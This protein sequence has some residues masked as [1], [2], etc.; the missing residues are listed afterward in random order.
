MAKDK[1]ATGDLPEHGELTLFVG[2][3][4]LLTGEPSVL[5]RG[6][7]PL[8]VRLLRHYATLAREN[9]ASQEHVSEALIVAGRID[10]WQMENRDK[11]KDKPD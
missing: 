7:N 3:P 6:S 8:L 1:K 11:V 4:S 5:F 10:R 9:L 2:S